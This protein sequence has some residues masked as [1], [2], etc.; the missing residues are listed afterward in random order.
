MVTYPSTGGGD[1]GSAVWVVE[2]EGIGS[3]T[4]IETFK[5]KKKS[6]MEK[7]SDKSQMSIFF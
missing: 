6:Q 4:K 7:K 1:S 3:Q 5:W 2:I